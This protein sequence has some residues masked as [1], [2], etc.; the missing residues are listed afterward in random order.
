[1]VKVGDRA[2]GEELDKEFWIRR[3][4]EVCDFTATHIP[5]ELVWMWVCKRLSVLEVKYL[6]RSLPSALSSA[7]AEQ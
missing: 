3:A 2:S 4:G 6:F 1:M 7:A 5:N